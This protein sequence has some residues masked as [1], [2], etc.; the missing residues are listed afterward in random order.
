MSTWPSSVCCRAIWPVLRRGWPR[1]CGAPS[2]SGF[3]LGPYSH[4]FALNY[5][6]W[7]RCEAG[8]LNRARM[9]ADKTIEL[10]QRHGFDYWQR[11]AA[12]EQ[13]AIDAR[14]LLASTDR[15]PTAVSAHIAAMTQIQ[16]TYRRVGA[17][18][19]RPINDAIVGRL[20]I[21]AG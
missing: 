2:S 1:R 15:D 10:S 9:V 8:Q 6:I 3:P 5:E 4:V 12:A 16:D 14:V 21:A 7:I 20:L 18:A 19:W 17:E 13:C 11:S